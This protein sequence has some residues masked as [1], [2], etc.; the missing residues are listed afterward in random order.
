MAT[1]I[2]TAHGEVF[3]SLLGVDR[4]FQAQ[5]EQELSQLVAHYKEGRDGIWIAKYKSQFAGSLCLDGKNTGL[6][7]PRLRF[8]IVRP[9]HQGRGIGRRLLYSALSFCRQSGLES[10][11]LW[12]FD[13]L[14]AAKHLYESMGFIPTEKR[15]IFCWGRNLLERKYVLAL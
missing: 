5:I 10:V 13:Q 9:E 8:M 14:L 2:V 3:P 4:Q 7:G 11:H 12:T 6:S 15:E 1:K